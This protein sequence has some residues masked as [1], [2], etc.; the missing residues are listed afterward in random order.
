MIRQTVIKKKYKEKKAS[1]TK[2]RLTCIFSFFIYQQRLK[3]I[4]EEKG[5]KEKMSTA[6]N[7]TKKDDD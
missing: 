4:T 2:I 1:K 5:E 7:E 3:A 6:E